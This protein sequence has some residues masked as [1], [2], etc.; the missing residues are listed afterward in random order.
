MLELIGASSTTADPPWFFVSP[1]M[2]NGSLIS[3]LKGL[4]SLDVVDILKMTQEIA[5]GMTYLHGKG[6]LH[7]DLK[8]SSPSFVEML[9]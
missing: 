7:G 2:K 9:C 8:A 3:Y 4:P 6:V 5:K 1:Y